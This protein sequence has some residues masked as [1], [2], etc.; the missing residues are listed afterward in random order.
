MTL[1][2]SEYTLEQIYDLLKDPKNSLNTKIPYS[3]LVKTNGKVLNLT[4]GRIWFN[5]L[6]PDDYILINKPIA[7]K[8]LSSI[9]ADIATKYDTTVASKV[10]S[11][12]NKEGFYLGTLVPTSFSAES[13][14]LPPELEKR[15]LELLNEDMPADQFVINITKLGNEYLDWLKANNDGLYDIIKSGAK[16]NP[17]EIGVIMFA[18][19]AVVGI[20]GKISK[21]IMGSVN[22]GFNLEDWYKSSDQSRSVL[23]I[24]AIGTAEP[25]S[26][27]REVFYANANTQLD[28][29]S[30]CKTK[31]YLELAIT[32]SIRNVVH[33][34]YY[35]DEK[36]NN[37]VKIEEDTEITGKIIKLRSPIYCKQKDNNICSICYGDLGD[38]LQTRNIG[39]LSGSVINVVGVNNYSM[40][41]RHMAS[42]VQIRPTNMITDFIRS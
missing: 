41:A 26:L 1:K 32:P 9:L 10:L 4:I 8:E 12:I 2:Q 27:G 7:K 11:T 28:Y 39:L 30:D 34:R 13:F 31:K 35:L 29:N 15:R 20:D 6:L 5:L 40:K 14:E 22:R 19:G 16:S 21:P 3:H 23:Y 38:K 33:G 24:R 17:T 25:G 37:L 42:Q 36:T 18:K